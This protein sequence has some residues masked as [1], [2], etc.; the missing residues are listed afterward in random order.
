MVVKR[1]GVAVSLGVMLMCMSGAASAATMCAGQ[2]RSL[3]VDNGAQLMVLPTFLGDWVQVC[4]ISTPWKGIS[5]DVCKSWFATLTA[6]RASQDTVMFRYN[7]NM[8][9]NGIPTYTNAPAP[10]YIANGQS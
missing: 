9:C 10:A 3:F 2:I 5:V 7:E 1:S 6:L 4:N 8:A